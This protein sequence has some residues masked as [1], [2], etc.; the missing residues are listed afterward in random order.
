[1]VDAATVK[2]LRE[3]TGVAMMECK[4]ALVESSGDLEAARL[5]LRNKGITKADD[6]RGRVTSEGL[7]ATRLLD[8]PTGFHTGAIVEVN[9][10]TDFV[11]RNDVFK[12][13]ANSLADSFLMGRRFSSLTGYPSVEDLREQHKESIAAAVLSL[14]ENIQ[15]RR[16][17]HLSVNQGV[18]NSYLHGGGRIGVLIALESEA[19]TTA[20]LAVAKNL[21]MHVAAANPTSAYEDSV[22]PEIVAREEAIYR[23]QVAE[24]P[25]LVGKPQKVLDGV[26]T[27]RLRKFLQEVVMTKQPMVTSPVQ[28]V[29]SWI[30][31]QEK[32]LGHPIKITGFIRYLV[33]EEI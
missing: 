9:S 17:E 25:K 11:S 3:E 30:A 28:S 20:L 8:G 13:L 10:E 18:V 31:D 29:E 26:V 1:M 6:K 32:E 19:D 27:G 2:K 22:P 4:K 24:D 12:T 16:A 7:V 5:W 33:G 15:V 21:A 23:T 14:G